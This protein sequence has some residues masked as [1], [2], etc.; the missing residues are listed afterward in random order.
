MN[1][2]MKRLI[3]LLNK[4]G[5]KVEFIKDLDTPYSMRDAQGDRVRGYDVRISKTTKEGERKSEQEIM[6]AIINRIA[7]DVTEALSKGQK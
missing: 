2:E 5:Y 6:A 4:D 1:E 7:S 3:D